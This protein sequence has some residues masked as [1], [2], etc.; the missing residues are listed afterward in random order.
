MQG[1]EQRGPQHQHPEV[2]GGHV[3]AHAYINVSYGIFHPCSKER[4][5]S[6]ISPGLKSK[7]EGQER[8]GYHHHCQS[9][10][11]P[12]YPAPNPSPPLPTHTADHHLPCTNAATTTQPPLTRPGAAV[13]LLLDRG[14][15]RTRP[16]PPSSSAPTPS[17]TRTLA[18]PSRS[19]R[20][21]SVKDSGTMLIIL[22]LLPPNPPATTTIPPRLLPRRT[23]SHFPNTSHTGWA[24]LKDRARSLDSKGP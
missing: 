13:H 17:R 1:P 16:P 9:P 15:R 24:S 19:P 2:V 12:T 7:G 4:E 3:T 10:F 11:P 8:R 5:G 21:L 14:R 6:L 22:F 18:S 20:C 23:L